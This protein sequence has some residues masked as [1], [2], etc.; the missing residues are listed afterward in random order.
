MVYCDPAQ[1]LYLI[2]GCIYNDGGSFNFPCQARSTCAEAIIPTILSGKP[3]LTIPCS[4]DRG[5]AG[6]EDY[7]LVITV[8]ASRIDDVVKLLQERRR[9]K[10]F[11]IP[12]YKNLV[13]QPIP[14]ETYKKLEKRIKII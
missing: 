8:S 2:H 11:I 4:G 9:N 3:Q 13:F 5:Y 6:T 14:S 7:E 10:K 1:A 12:V